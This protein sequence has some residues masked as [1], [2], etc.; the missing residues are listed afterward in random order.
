MHGVCMRAY[1]HACVCVCVRV[2]VHAYVS[3]VFGCM[4]QINSISAESV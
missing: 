2:C 4:T 3:K 1:M